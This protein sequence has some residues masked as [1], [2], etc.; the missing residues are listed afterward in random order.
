MTLLANM[1]AAEFAVKYAHD[2]LRGRSSNRSED[3]VHTLQQNLRDD[4]GEGDERVM[5]NLS[6]GLNIGLK[7]QLIYQDRWRTISEAR[8]GRR[9]R[10][11]RL[12]AAAIIQDNVGNCFEHCVLACHYLNGRGITS[13]MAETD[14]NTNHV[15]VLI[16]APPGL[17]GQRFN[18]TAANPGGISNGNTVVCDPWY[19][20]WFSVQQDW[21]RK[22][23]RIFNT[24][25]KFPPMPNP[26]PLTLTDGVHVT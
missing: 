18:V 20:E 22:M 16:G 6:S 21:G 25:T 10:G 4:F 17:D 7:N 5:L 12:N 9:E 1:I 23:W 13:Y 11:A 3:I 24:T 8:D 2:K 26:V 15:F 14:D 19:H